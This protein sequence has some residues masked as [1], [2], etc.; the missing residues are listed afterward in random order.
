M[1]SRS[2]RLLTGV[3][4]LGVFSSSGCASLF[5]FKSAHEKDLEVQVEQLKGQLDEAG[6]S[7]QGLQERIDRLQVELARF[8]DQRTRDLQRLTQEKEQAAQQAAE[9]KEQENQ[10]LL[11]A[12]KRLA[13][14]LKQELG[15]AK[16]KLAMTERGL[17]LTFLDEIFFDSGKAEVKQEGVGTLEKVAVV[18]KETVPDSPV[19]VEGYTD[20]EPIKYSGWKSN[21]ELS[22]ARALAVVHYFIDYQGL[23]PTRLRAVGFGEFH[24]VTEND[25]PEGRRQNRRVE[26][27]IL[28]KDLKKSK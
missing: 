16:A 23:E 9:E 7:R 18:L 17:V 10:D 6:N 14:S 25:T 4:F 15:D 19:A 5:G 21:W 22:S 28:P 20:N 8:Q 1:N 24:P 27:V 26:I 12:Q 13:E 2:V 11:D 3:I